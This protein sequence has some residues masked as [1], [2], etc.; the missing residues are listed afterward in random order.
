MRCSVRWP[1]KAHGRVALDVVPGAPIACSKAHALPR[2][3][4]SSSQPRSS[5]SAR[6]E[7]ASSRCQAPTRSNAGSAGFS[8]PT[9]MIPARR[10]SDEDVAGDQVAV[11]HHVIGASRQRP[12]ACPPASKSRNVQELSTALK[13]GL[14]PG[15]M[16]SQLAP[17]A[18][19]VERPAAGVDGPRVPDE[20]GQVVGKQDR[21][22]RVLVGRRSPWQPGLHRPWQRV[23]RSGLVERDWLGRR[24]PCA[25][26]QLTAAWASD[27]SHRR[28]ASTSPGS[29]ANRATSLSPMRKSALTVPCEVTCLIG[30]PRHSGNCCSTSSRTVS[31][32]TGSW[33]GC[34]CTSGAFALRSLAAI[35]FRRPALPPAEGVSPPRWATRFKAYD[36]KPMGDQGCQASTDL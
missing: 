18:L 25:S 15:I 17:P 21:F 30:S 24:E 32:E 23:A 35:A 3:H 27:S 16:G 11:G 29:K 5:R 4:S 6:R 8:P 12:H 26:Q 9:S 2:S 1:I 19:A 34:I 28:V 10:L 31:R 13:A 7:P 36:F 20:L 22:A 33:S 14:H